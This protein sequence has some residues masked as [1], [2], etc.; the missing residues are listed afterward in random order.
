MVPSAEEDDMSGRSPQIGDTVKVND[1]K[2]GVITNIFHDDAG[3][4]AS[5]VVKVSENEWH[6]IGMT[7][8][9]P[10]GDDA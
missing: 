6:S 7:N 10:R 3:N 4:V 1:L 8:I 5:L 2:E 9:K